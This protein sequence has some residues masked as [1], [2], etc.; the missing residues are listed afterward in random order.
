[1]EKIWLRSYPQGVPAEIN[2]DIYQSLI[3]MFEQSCAQYA[4]LP[5]FYNLGTAFTYR[6][7]EAN[8]RAFAAYLQQVLK[9]KK[10][11]RLA[12]MLPNILQYPVVLFGA[13]R[14]GLV[15][16]NVNPLY[17]AP[18]LAYQLRDS[19]AE[20]IVVLAN[21]ANTVQKALPE[22]PLKNVIVT[23]IGDFF[24]LPKSSLMHFVLKYIKKKIPNWSITNAVN[25]KQALSKGKNLSLQP[26]EFNNT[27][28][29]FLQYTGGTTGV[30]KGA[31]L[32]HRNLISNIL[33]SKAWFKPCEL[34]KEV[35]LT[36]LPLYHIFSLTANCLFTTMIGGLNVLITNPRDVPHM[37]S[38]MERFKLT[39]I[40]GV[41]TLF[42]A[43][44]KNPELKNVDFRHLKLTLGGGMAVQKVVADKWRQVTGSTL[45]EAY[46]LTETSPC[47]AINPID[48]KEYN[49]SIG[50]PVPCTEVTILSD[51]GKE[52]PVGEPGEI[53]IKGPQV[54]LGY[55]KNPQETQKIFTQDGWLLTGDIGC[56]D[57]NGYFRILERK[58]DMILVSG[59]NVYPNEIE[60][61]LVRIPGVV[62]AAVIG[63][64]DK[65]SGEAVKAFIV[66]DD[67]HLTEQDVIRLSHKSLTGY[68]IPKFIEFCDELPKSNVG[69][70]LRRALRNEHA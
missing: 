10:G 18:E 46:G 6:Q 4:D 42:N 57:A 34:G 43:L 17:T 66:K 47:V 28:I 69:K 59:F 24:S 15:I 63:I 16:V 68:K 26:V 64:P 49:G 55:W 60:D 52:M 23:K 29:A 8:S 11:D 38:E 54:M 31:M 33:Q 19:G 21:F 35:M 36:A 58:K 48:L 51:E 7:L 67:P 40:T 32:T 2:P 61:V 41:N 1:M 3:E 13:M 27:D 22:T 25:F 65:N 14:A 9:L 45:I 12:I 62:E 37:I 56:M 20:T 5:A 30:S 44:L 53:A 70:I 50:L 39:L